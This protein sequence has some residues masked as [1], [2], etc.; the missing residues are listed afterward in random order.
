MKRITAILVAM[1]ACTPFAYAGPHA[2]PLRIVCTV[3]TEFDPQRCWV[4]FG[5]PVVGHRIEVA[6]MT[7]GEKLI[8]L[9]IENSGR[10]YVLAE[11]VVIQKL[12][13]AR[14]PDKR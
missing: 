11:V 13:D 5:E 2:I 12:R 6:S 3:P 9:L 1:L 7:E 8:A 10:R 4:E 14:R